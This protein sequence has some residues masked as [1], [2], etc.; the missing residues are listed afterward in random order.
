MGASGPTS[1]RAVLASH[2][3]RLDEQACLA[4]LDSVWVARGF[5]THPD[6]GFLRATRH[7]QTTVVAPVSG[8]R[9]TA[10]SSVTALAPGGRL[11]DTGH[12]PAG[13]RASHVDVVVSF[14][15][16]RRGRTLAERHGARFVDSAALVG[17]L[18]YALD[19]DVADR[20]CTRHLGAPIDGLRPPLLTR[21]RRR[22]ATLGRR[23]AR[24]VTPTPRG[25]AAFVALV[26][27][28][29]GG[30]VSLG[31]VDSPLDAQSTV[32]ESGVPDSSGGG[33][34]AE[35]LTETV[36][37]EGPT[38][39][40]AVVTAP[41]L[42]RDPERADIEPLED[43]DLASVPGVS[44][45]GITNLT[46]LGDAHEAALSNRSYTLW[47][48]TFQPRDA[49]PNATR[50]QYDTDIGVAEDRYL[51][52][53]NVDAGRERARLRAVYFDGRDWYV[54]ESDDGIELTRRVAEETRSPPVKFDLR[55]LNAELVR[56]YLA[57]RTT[58]VSGK[59][60]AGNTTY[61]R[62]EGSGRPSIGGVEPVRDYRF[63]AFVDDDGFVSEATMTYVLVTDA[64][65]YPV[66]FE[67]TYGN[68][69]ST[70]VSRPS[71]VGNETVQTETNDSETTDT[72]ST[73]ETAHTETVRFETTRNETGENKPPS[74]RR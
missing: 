72:A 8:R 36:T 63:V 68:V 73:T 5:E 14:G 54:T 33:S 37:T 10:L 67:W 18:L 64:G 65:A 58:N 24:V 21:S 30:A 52:V 59:I 6:D 44:E 56:Q 57:T 48:D 45:T 35:N 27:V 19:R 22:V 49:S 71:W 69:G 34:V 62:V 29:S 32:G 61:Y 43:G 40:D 31:V 7:G 12:G 60:S 3:A 28:V 1:R 13:R 20:L 42:G 2:L 70:T 50:I 23:A 17:M 11:G 53:E 51:I 26:L 38:S 39:G 41:T 15:S 9:W 16:D 66:R 25:I 4:F 47:L 46:A 74:L 55:T